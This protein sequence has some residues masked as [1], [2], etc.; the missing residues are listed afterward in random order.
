M[1]GTEHNESIADCFQ[2]LSLEDFT[3]DL[4]PEL[5]AQEPVFERSSSRLLVLNRKNRSIEHRQFSDLRDY[6]Q[7]GDILVLN[8]TRVIPARIL[9][10]RETGGLV[11]ILLLKP[12]AT[13][14]GCWQ[15]MATPLRKLKPGERL[16]VDATGGEDVYLS[17]AGFVEA[18]DSQRRVILDFGGLK[19]VHSLLSK[20]G[21]APLPPY[22]VRQRSSDTSVQS[23]K[24]MERYQTVY[25]KAPGAVAA[26][27]AGL[28]FTSGLL[29]KIQQ[30]GVQVCYV[31][32][33]VGPGTFKP[34][35]TSLEE[36]NIEAEEFFIQQQTADMVN[37]CRRNGGRVLAVGTTTCRSLESAGES[38]ILSSVDGASSSLYIRP[39]HRFKMIDALI[40]NFHLSRSSL[41]VLVAAFAGH[42]L[43]MS[44][45]RE[46]IEKRYRFYSYGD[47]M[48]IF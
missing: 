4:P 47:A 16:K 41:L 28:H 48:L 15:A 5:I 35:S 33:H 31:T 7:E 13:S 42:D 38:G 14:P 36:H 2:S 26:P 27:T 45:Y 21:Q 34:I 23:T 25:A 37:E 46:A 44:A 43:I 19:E 17:V 18:P 10:R 20:I 9:A 29:E 11:D 32:L 6:L 1:S 30:N 3:Y 24:D 39:G 40:T 22:I 8:N 12:E